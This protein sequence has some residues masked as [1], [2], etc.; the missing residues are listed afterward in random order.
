MEFRPL[1]RGKIVKERGATRFLIRKNINSLQPSLKL[2]L[3]SSVAKKKKYI[4]IYIIKIRHGKEK[5][6]LR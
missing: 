6:N 3:S 2:S 5:G 4:Y 1:R